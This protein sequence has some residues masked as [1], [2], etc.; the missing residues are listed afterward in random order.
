MG[1]ACFSGMYTP[2][3]ASLS[4]SSL[5]VPLRRQAELD[6]VGIN[7]RNERHR[8]WA[9]FVSNLRGEFGEIGAKACT[10]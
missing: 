4:S 8:V 2:V 6:L 3:K 9:R 5:K 7:I 1:P 10:R